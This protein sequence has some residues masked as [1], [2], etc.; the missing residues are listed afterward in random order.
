MRVKRVKPTLKAHLYYP[1]V[2]HDLE[3]TMLKGGVPY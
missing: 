1:C 2:W 3:K